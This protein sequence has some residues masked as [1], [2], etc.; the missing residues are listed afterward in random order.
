[1]KKVFFIAI[2]LIVGICL[3]A[4]QPVKYCTVSLI[5][6]MNADFTIMVDSGQKVPVSKN[7]PVKDSEGKN[8]KFE[9][10]AGVFNWMFERGWFYVNELKNGKVLFK[11]PD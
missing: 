9:S 6:N 7:V 3:Q 1:M 5:Q 2:F 8:L 10:E 11:R 4:Q